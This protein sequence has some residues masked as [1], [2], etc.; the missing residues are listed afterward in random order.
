M[1]QCIG[2][3]CVQ[4]GKRLLCYPIQRIV[5]TCCDVVECLVAVLCVSRWLL[6]FV[7]TF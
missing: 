6:S 3:C 5:E 1:S 4:C 7:Y 2:P